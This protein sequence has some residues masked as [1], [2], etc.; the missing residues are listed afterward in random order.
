MN[1]EVPRGQ[2]GLASGMWGS[3]AV[4]SSCR[5]SLRSQGTWG[6]SC[7]I[8]MDAEG[9][10]DTVHYSLNKKGGRAVGEP[11]GESRAPFPGSGRWAAGS[12]HG[13]EA[14]LK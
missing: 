8:S 11:A 4:R 1:R 13:S 3:L 9:A 12:R 14:E 10:S 2:P 7:G 5:D 6:E